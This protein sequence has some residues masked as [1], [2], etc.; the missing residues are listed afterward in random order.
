MI[1]R[2]QIIN[3]YSNEEIASRI[4][5]HATS[6]EVA[7]AL[8]DGSYEKRPNMLQFQSDVVQMARKGVT[9]FHYSAERWSNPMAISAGN[10]DSLRIGWDMVIDIDSKLGFDES[11]IGAMAVC[12]FLKKYGIK[13][14]TVKFS[15]RRGF[16]VILPW[17]MFPTNINYKPFH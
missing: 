3:Y 6:R 17:E 4:F 16:H 7:G 15:G 2:S 10:Y 14:H 5:R 11:K 13:N 12:D 8:S 9:S 1:T